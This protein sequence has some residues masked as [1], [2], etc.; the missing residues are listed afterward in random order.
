MKLTIL[1][2]VCFLFL[3]PVF[4][5]T[6]D[7]LLG[8]VVGYVLGSAGKNTVVKHSTCKPP[9]SYAANHSCYNLQLVNE[10]YVNEFVCDLREGRSCRL[11]IT[12]DCEGGAYS[13]YRDCYKTPEEVETQRKENEAYDAEL[14]KRCDNGDFFACNEKGIKAGI[15]IVAMAFALSIFSSTSNLVRGY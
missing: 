9:V 7:A 11:Y 3:V 10:D 6:G 4:A 12:G 5:D 1:F 2:F 14:K 15:F 8:G 13:A